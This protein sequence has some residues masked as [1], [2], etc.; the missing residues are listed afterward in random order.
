ML[1]PDELERPLLYQ[2]ALYDG[3]FLHVRLPAI[4][5]HLVRGFCAAGRLFVPAGISRTPSQMQLKLTST[6]SWT[7]R[8]LRLGPRARVPLRT[9]RRLPHEGVSNR[10]TNFQFHLESWHHRHYSRQF[11]GR[12]SRGHE[13]PSNNN[14]NHRCGEGLLFSETRLINSV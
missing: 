8:D 7:T 4:R 1:R 9:D 11:Q 2:E 14:P 3:K 13:A 6:R 12:H 10:D 5:G